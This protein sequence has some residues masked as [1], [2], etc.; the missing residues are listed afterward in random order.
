MNLNRRDF[1][2]GAASLAGA[3]ALPMPVAAAGTTRAYGMIEISASGITVSVYRLSRE[4]L[5]PPPGISGFEWLSPRKLGDPY[6]VVASPLRPG[7]DEAAASETADIVADHI[8]R[9]KARYELGDADADIAVVASSGVA[10]YSGALIDLLRRNVKARTGLDMDVVTPRE[11]ARLAFDWIVPERRRANVLQVDIGSG[12]TKGGYYDRSGRRGRYHDLSVP[13]GTKTLAGAV[14]KRW[15]SVRTDDFGARTAEYY[16]DTIAPLVQPQL[17][18][19]PETM[20]RP[21]IYM[22]GGIVWA[23]ATIVRPQDMAENR[24]WVRLAPDDFATLRRYVEAGTPYG[25]G[26]PGSMTEEHKARVRKALSAI[27][28]TFNPHQL[29][30]GAGLGEGLAK[31]LAF[32]RR[33]NILFATFA[34]NSWSSQYLI[35]KFSGRWAH[36]NV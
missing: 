21:D 7:A 31:Q 5:S 1:I 14:K 11:E 22:T 29:A 17:A 6:S 16:E 19:A 8:A 3:A 33:R 36:R 26:L 9:L 24:N 13:Y 10:S 25:P 23:T 32:D 30:A 4:M 18:A 2:G 15:P 28:N 12:N 35:E 20:S 27:R 34:S